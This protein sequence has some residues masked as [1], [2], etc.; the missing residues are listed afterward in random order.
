MTRN[1]NKSK[2]CPGTCFD[3]N[4]NFM[5]DIKELYKINKLKTTDSINLIVVDLEVNGVTLNALVD[6]GAT[7]NYI[8]ES[9]ANYLKIFNSQLQFDKNTHQ[10]QVANKTVLTSLGN[11]TLDFNLNDNSFVSKFTVME[12]LSFDIILGLSFLKS[13]C[14]II[15]TE[16]GDLYF[17]K[18][19]SNL[20]VSLVDH[21]EIPAF[22]TI[23]ALVSVPESLKKSHVLNN[24]PYF[25]QKYGVYP[26]QGLVDASTSKFTIYLANL[27]DKTKLLPA[28]T[29]VGLLIPEEEY[30]LHTLK[31]SSSSNIN[32]YLTAIDNKEDTLPKDK[33]NAELLNPVESL[34]LSLSNLTSE[35]SNAVRQL[36]NEYSDIFS[37][38]GPG[39]TDLVSHYIDVGSHKPIYQM[40][41]RVSPAERKVIESEVARMLEEKIIEPSNSPWASPVVLITKKDGSI[42]FCVDY[43]KLNLLKTKDVYPL[44]RI[45]DCLAALSG[46]KYISTFDLIQGYHQIP[47]DPKSKDKT[48]FICIAGLFK[49]NVMPF[50]L[51]NAPATFQRFMDAVLAGLKWRN[52]LV[53]MDDICVFSTSFENHLADLKLVFEWLRSAKLKLKP[54]KCHLFKNELKFLGHVISDHGIKPDPDKIKAI[55]NMPIPSNVSKLQS[56][57]GMCSY[58][59]KF[60]QDFSQICKPLYELT[61]FG[62]KYLWTD[63]HTD[64][65]NKLKEALSSSPI[66]AHPNFDLPFQV[67]TDASV[68]GLGAVLSQVI[69]G[70]EHVIQY[71]SRVLQPA[72]RKWCVREL[73]GLACK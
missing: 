6:T 55:S 39:A 37:L 4:C 47:M 13:N 5:S 27:T 2:K 31:A 58:Y 28:N 57:L 30:E 33:G 19:K 72:E 71:I 23:T 22:S 48:S 3:F 53:Y 40:P 9:A 11:I 12:E 63:T 62:V 65:V 46:A 59:R 69:N 73:E 17:D 25:G 61:R 51:T 26:A 36:V 16:D 42:R 20:V 14:V 49:Y 68:E 32:E 21:I 56:F 35:Q 66:L 45:D 44:P 1:S 43:R 60:I 24:K 10:I 29:S 52:L 41:Y 34:D 7:S 38:K 50:G 54:S 18:P 15:D 67:H 8:S 64:A 70:K